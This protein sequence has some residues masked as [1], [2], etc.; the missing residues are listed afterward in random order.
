MHESWRK[1]AEEIVANMRRTF[2]DDQ[3]LVVT[4]PAGYRHLNLRAYD[5]FLATMQAQGFTLVADMARPGITHTPASTLAP[6]MIRVMRSADGRVVANYYQGKARLGKRLRILAKGLLNLRLVTAPRMF[7][8]GMVTRHCVDFETEL[9]NGL[10]ICTCN[11]EVAASLSTPPALIKRFHPWKT[12]VPV[13][14]DDH[15]RSLA[16]YLRA[17]PAVAPVPVESVGDVMRGAWRQDQIKLAHRKSLDWVSH[18]E[19]SR[20]G[21]GNQDEVNRAIFDEVQK[22]L[23]TERAGEA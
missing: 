1:A 21:A 9:D 10:F 5:D 11:V 8:R 20:L 6:T 2:S 7:A 22:L 16:D 19:I 12:P 18:A 15:L 4:E 14:L 3:G 13:L 23:A 17:N